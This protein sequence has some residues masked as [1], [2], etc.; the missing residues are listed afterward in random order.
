MKQTDNADDVR[1]LQNTQTMKQK[2]ETSDI[3]IYVCSCFAVFLLLMLPY[4]FGGAGYVY[5]LSIV[6]WPFS[7]LYE[8]EYQYTGLL[9]S[10]FISA[11]FYGFIF[12]GIAVLIKLFARNKERHIHWGFVFVL[13]SFVFFLLIPAPFIV[14]KSSYMGIFRVL[15]FP[16]RWL[17]H[18]FGSGLD[19]FV[20]VLAVLMKYSLMAVLSSLIYGLLPFCICKFVMKM[21]KSLNEE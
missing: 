11:M 7:G 6:C 2:N 5:L 16:Y 21:H 20:Y 1:K 18:F 13:F 19:K 14:F 17:S 4:C 15:L 8:L 3:L 10:L 12:T 9:L